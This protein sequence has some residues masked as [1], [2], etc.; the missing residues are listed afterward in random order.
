MRYAARRARKQAHTQGA[1]SSATSS[2]RQC[3]GSYCGHRP[4]S[5][6]V[7]EWRLHCLKNFEAAA[8]PANGVVKATSSNLQ[9]RQLRQ[10]RQ[11]RQ[12]RQLQQLR[13]RGAAARAHRGRRGC[14]ST[15]LTAAVAA[16]VRAGLTAAVAAEDCTELVVWLESGVGFGV[17]RCRA[18]RSCLKQGR[19]GTRT[20]F[21][22]R[23]APPHST[24]A[25]H[26]PLARGGAPLR[27]PGR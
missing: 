20:L 5:S 13:E 21:H 19:T 25:I 15:R 12:L 14:G 11:P 16:E 17:V 9:P 26:H 27:L 3:G 10:L 24:S 4:R 7:R 18:G 8:A 23:S 1:G 6:V 22:S 2:A